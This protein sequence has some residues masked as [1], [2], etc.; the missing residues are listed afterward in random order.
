M[1]IHIMYRDLVLEKHFVG[2]DMI[3]TFSTFHQR[4]TMSISYVKKMVTGLKLY[5]NQE[6]DCFVQG[7]V[8]KSAIRFFW[9]SMISLFRVSMANT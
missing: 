2:L 4:V 5:P 7:F 1:L 9:G 6:S 3:S 8:R